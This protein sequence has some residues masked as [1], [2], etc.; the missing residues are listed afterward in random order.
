[1]GRN[2]S[3]DDG[4]AVIEMAEEGYT[5]VQHVAELV[6]TREDFTRIYGVRA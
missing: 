6:M 2:L 4:D 3:Q 5:D 1:M